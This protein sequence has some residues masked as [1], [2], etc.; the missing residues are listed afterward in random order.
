MKRLKKTIILAE[1]YTIKEYILN[2]IYNTHIILVI[3]TLVIK[4]LLGYAYLRVKSSLSDAKYIHMIYN[5][6]RNILGLCYIRMKIVD[7][8][9]VGILVQLTINKCFTLTTISRTSRRNFVPTLKI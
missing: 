6:G 4:S 7:H 9:V 5:M 3:M 2:Y 8:A 1:R